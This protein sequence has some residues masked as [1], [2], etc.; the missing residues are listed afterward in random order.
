MTN[1][2]AH[3]ATPR[4]VGEPNREDRCWLLRLHLPLLLQQV[5]RRSSH[6][7]DGCMMSYSGRHYA[8]GA[9]EEAF[10]L[11]IVG[12]DHGEHGFA[13]YRGRQSSIEGYYVYNTNKFNSHYA[14]VVK[15]AAAVLGQ[16]AG[17]CGADCARSGV[18]RKARGDTQAFCVIE[19]IMQ[20]NI[21]K[22]VRMEKTS[23]A[24]RRHK[25]NGGQ[26]H[27]SPLF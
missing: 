14:G 25:G 19:Q 21:V 7:G 24:I 15:T 27:Q 22:C 1:D 20:P 17:N 26:L 3:M 4:G 9:R 8:D 5:N 2:E 11:M 13:S 10:R 23:N 12:L 6:R 16:E 18:C